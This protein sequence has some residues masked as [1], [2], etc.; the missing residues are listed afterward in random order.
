LEF[1]QILW[2]KPNLLSTHKILLKGEKM[3][4]MILIPMIGILLLTEIGAGVVFSEEISQEI[5]RLDLSSR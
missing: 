3:R 1:V 5:Q 4:K 2:A